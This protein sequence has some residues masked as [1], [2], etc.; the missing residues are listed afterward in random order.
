MSTIQVRTFTGEGLHQY[1]QDLALLRMEVFRDFPY[2][3]DGTLA[4]EKN[5]LRTY[6]EATQSA[7]IVAFDENR[8]IGAS[9]CIALAEEEPPIKQAFAASSFPINTVM[10]LGESVLKKSYR[11]KGIGVEFFRQRESYARQLDK[12][13]AAFCA[14]IRPEDHPLRPANYHPLHQF[15]QNRGYHLYP[16]IKVK[17]QWKDVDQE[18]STAKELVFW[19]KSL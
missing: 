19:I 7:V 3:Y 14:V 8:V 1:I 9:T 11:G 15:W 12:Q 6:I 18:E 10:Y 4:Y 13:Y 16:D 17:M 2:L 5:Y